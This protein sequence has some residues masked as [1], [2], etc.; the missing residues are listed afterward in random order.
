MFDNDRA[1]HGGGEGLIRAMAQ[2][3]LSAG[4]RS[5]LLLPIGYPPR[6]L[7]DG[8][9]VRKPRPALLFLRVPEIGERPQR[10]R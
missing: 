8:A 9:T 3:S 4:S 6:A 5:Q 10:V 2:A 1:L 7:L